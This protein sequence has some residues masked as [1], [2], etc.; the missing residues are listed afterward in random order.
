MKDV[1]YN[2]TDDLIMMENRKYMEQM[3]ARSAMYGR[4]ASPVDVASETSDGKRKT[5]IFSIKKKQSDM[6]QRSFYNAE[7]DIHC[8]SRSDIKT[9]NWL[10]SAW[11]KLFDK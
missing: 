3:K 10:L 7:N 6:Q 4:A 5:S 9:E 11:H 1:N 8:I 2:D